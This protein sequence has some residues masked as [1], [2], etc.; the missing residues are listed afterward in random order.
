MNELKHE[1]ARVSRKLQSSGFETRARIVLHN[2]PPDLTSRATMKHE[3]QSP[4]IPDKTGRELMRS[5]GS[6]IADH[7]VKSSRFVSRAKTF[8]RAAAVF[9]MLV[10]AV[11][12]I[13]WLSDVD[14]LKSIYGDITMKANTALSLMLMGA[15]LWTLRL[16]NHKSS[17]RIGEIC[18]ATAGLIGL[19]T[20][21]EHVTGWNLYIDQ[22][23]FTEPPGALATASP[24]RMGIT[25]SSCF[26]IFGIAMLLVYRQRGV[27]FAQ[28][29]S[30]ASGF[31]ALL[32]IM[33]YAYGAEALF[34]VAR[35]TGIALPTGIALFVLCFG[36]LGA[37]LDD[38]MLS[39][40]CGETAAAI[41]TR[42][43][44]VVAICVPFALGW[45]CIAGQRAGYFDL[46]FGTALS[47]SAIIMLFLLSIWRVAVR[48]RRVEQRHQATEAK[49]ERAKARLAGIVESSEDAI[50]SESLDGVIASWNG[51]AERLFEY[52]A[53]EAIGKSITIIIPPERLNEERLILEKLRNGE[54]LDTFDTVRITKS[55]RRINL[56]LTVSPIRDQHGEVIGAS[57][58]A[59]DITERRNAERELERLLLQERSLRAE[60]ERAARLKDEFLATVSHELR[61]PL[62][63]ILGWSIILSKDP[64]DQATVANAIAAIERNAKSQAQLI[65]D[66][67]DVSRIISGSL[68]LDV[69]P[70]ALT[71]VV[72]AAM[73]SVQPAAD[74]KEIQLQMIVDPT[75]DNVRGD[76]VRLQQVIWNLLSNSIK[77][78]PKGGQVVVNVDRSNSMA[79]VTVTDTGEGIRAEFLPYVFDRFKQAD[80]SITRKYGGLGL[81][82][83]IARHLTEMHGGTIEVDS[84]GE[85][86]GATFRFNLPLVAVTAVS[87]IDSIKGAA[88]E[89]TPAQDLPDLRGIRVLV[90]DDA[91]DTREM[92]RVV[93]ERFGADVTT[94]A[95]ARETLDVLPAWQPNVLVSDIGMPEEDG[96]SLIRKVRALSS[97]KGGD[98]PAIALTGYVRVEE[99]MRALDAGYQMF[100][101]KP[102]EVGELATIIASL[103]GRAERSDIR[104]LKTID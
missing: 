53:A 101:P 26:I 79:R 84:A 42:R 61:T 30:I 70:I 100:V 93:L 25:A 56:S 37:C 52:T 38:G 43:L 13:G 41:M 18:A 34:G 15:S 65:E 39:V 1:V 87:D 67:L 16:A 63:A 59:R 36:I 78:T 73:D 14:W 57:K 58:A 103:I 90:V 11:A 33:G 9:V 95:S 35:Y 7:S 5:N 102:V 104:A 98:I 85:G 54:R 27:S 49:F 88:A 64:S 2:R 68:V 76:A 96:Y 71:A 29:L 20:L 51:A 46:G 32:A 92:L 89:L 19:L 60:A 6:Q 69:Q 81:G 75:A 44:T 12:M 55:G 3:I 48:L 45:L 86:L 82:L 77:F 62:S 97:E 23:L 72:K 40:V 24:G 83:A 8:S 47:V 22:L 94:A 10:G 74:A 31:W 91:A 99:R 21:T 28:A 4:S 66:L 50:I 80:G 17:R